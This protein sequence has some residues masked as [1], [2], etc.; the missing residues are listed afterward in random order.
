MKPLKFTNFYCNDIFIC[1]F[2]PILLLGL[3]GAGKTEIAHKIC[4]TDRNDYCPTKGCAAYEFTINSFK[5]KLSEIGGDINIR[6]I[7][8]YYF[9]MSF[10]VI[11]VID[12]SENEVRMNEARHILHNLLKHPHLEG[13]CFLIIG[14]KQDLPHS[15]D[16]VDL[17]YFLDLDS[18]VNKSKSPCLLEMTGSWETEA[19]DDN[20]LEK[21]L[22]WLVLT[23]KE[24]LKFIKNIV[25]YYQDPNMTI[26]L[27]KRPNTGS[28]KTKL[29]DVSKIRP[30]TAPKKITE[31][32]QRSIEFTNAKKVKNNSLQV[33]DF[34]Y[35]VVHLVHITEVQVHRIDE[36]VHCRK[37]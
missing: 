2:F 9:Y 20:N 21:S 35:T 12:S 25:K 27:I 3:N 29:F 19:L 37:N 6:Q 32:N 11:F 23:I 4:K 33:E 22:T 10:G 1:S 31:S 14:N 7:W 15:I 34:D 16:Y 5:V 18:L 13:K 26:N 30:D 36:E 24:R 28:Y 17:L 8:H